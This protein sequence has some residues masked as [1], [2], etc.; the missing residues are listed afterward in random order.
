ICMEELEI[1]GPQTTSVSDPIT[2]NFSVVLYPS[3]EGKD[4]STPV[5]PYPIPS[6]ATNPVKKYLCHTESRNICVLIKGAFDLSTVELKFHLGG[7]K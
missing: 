5:I 4:L 1:E 7:F 2:Q 3:L 6:P